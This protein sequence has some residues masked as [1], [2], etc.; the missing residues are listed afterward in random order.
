M[1][2]ADSNTLRLWGAI[3]I[4]SV[5]EHSTNKSILDLISNRGP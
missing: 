3:N 1:D 2:K 4:K 5:Y